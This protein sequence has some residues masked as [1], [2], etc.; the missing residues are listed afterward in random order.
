MDCF[1]KV[2]SRFVM[3]NARCHGPS[4]RV[5][6]PDKVGDVPRCG[7]RSA[8]RKDH[9]LDYIYHRLYSNDIPD[10]K[11]GKKHHP[12]ISKTHTVI[13]YFYHLC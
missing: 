10:S 8:I 4:C 13:K 5:A 6:M 3:L 11:A 12:R 1:W 2:L 7:C 9:M